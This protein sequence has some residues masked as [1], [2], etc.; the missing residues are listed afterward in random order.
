MWMEDVVLYFQ[1]G[2]AD[3]LGGLLETTER[4]L[5]PFTCRPPPPFRP[6][7]STDHHPP[8]RPARPPPT[9]RPWSSTD[10]HPPIR[11]T[12]PDPSGPPKPDQVQHVDHLQEAAAGAPSEGGVGFPEVCAF[13]AAFP[14]RHLPPE[15]V[16]TPGGVSIRRSWSV[17]PQGGAAVPC[18]PQGLSAQLHQ[19]VS[20]HRLHLQ[21]RVRWVICTHNCQD[22]EQVW[23]ILNRSVQSSVLPTCNANI[24]RENLEI[25]VFCDVLY[26]EQVGRF[27]KDQ[28]Q[29]SG[30]ISLWVHP[31]GNIYSM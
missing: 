7:S 12:G 3:G 31:L 13:Q 30:T 11:L 14:D 15:G 28:L 29:L 17:C 25:W 5:Q 18:P 24:Q 6:W 26:A 19:L 10:H 22:L 1:S 8:I 20:K 9:C 4:I 16:S 23:Q 21:H 27:L 2:S